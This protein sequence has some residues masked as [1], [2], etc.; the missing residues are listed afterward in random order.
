MKRKP[1]P[2]EKPSRPKFVAL[3]VY[4]GK[5]PSEDTFALLAK[6]VSIHWF[7]KFQ[8]DYFFLIPQ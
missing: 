2:N 1:F 5:V 4:T 7:S 8:Q 6:P 3:D